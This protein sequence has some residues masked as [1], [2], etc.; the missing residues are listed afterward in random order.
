MRLF[1]DAV[2][3]YEPIITILNSYMYSFGYN[4]K[5]QMHQSEQK[6]EAYMKILAYE[7]R[8]WHPK[9]EK[10]REWMEIEFN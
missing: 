7:M 9:K 6:C 5:T 1:K 3:K 2:F 4:H 8:N 10:F